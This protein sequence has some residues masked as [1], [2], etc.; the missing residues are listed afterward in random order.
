MIYNYFIANIKWSVGAVIYKTAISLTTRFCCEMKLV[1]HF[2][3][4]V[5]NMD[6]PPHLAWQTKRIKKERRV[7]RPKWEMIYN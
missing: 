7:P 1:M 5:L 6:K 3:P 4:C 2:S